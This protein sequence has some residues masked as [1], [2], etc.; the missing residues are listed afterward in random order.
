MLARGRVASY[1]CKLIL[2][3][4]L[5]YFQLLRI[6]DV[7]PTGSEPCDSSE[8]KLRN[9]LRSRWLR[10]AGVPEDVITPET[11][12]VCARHF[13]PNA[14]QHIDTDQKKMRRLKA[15]AVPLMFLPGQKIESE[16]KK[17]SVEIP[18]LAFRATLD[19]KSADEE[20][21]KN[22]QS[23]EDEDRSPSAEENC[24]VV[25]DGA[26]EDY[27][28]NETSFDTTVLSTANSNHEPEKHL[29]KKDSGNFASS[30][31]PVVSKGDAIE[32]V[33]TIES[34]DSASK[35]GDN[36][37]I[38]AEVLDD[39]SEPVLFV[40]VPDDSTTLAATTAKSRSVD[41]I[42]TIS[43]GHL[44]LEAEVVM[45]E[46]KNTSATTENRRKNGVIAFTEE[47]DKDAEIETTIQFALI[48]D[49]IEMEDEVIQDDTAG[50][51][52]GQTTDE[53]VKEISR[54]NTS[55]GVRFSLRNKLGQCIVEE[56]ETDSQDS[57]RRE[58]AAIFGQDGSETGPAKQNSRKPAKVKPVNDERAEIQHEKEI[59][60]SSPASQKSTESLAGSSES[61]TDSERRTLRS[62]LLKR[63]SEG[64]LEKPGPSKKMA[65]DEIK[66]QA[67]MKY[68]PRK[69]DLAKGDSA[70]PSASPPVLMGRRNLQMLLNNYGELIAQDISQK[71]GNLAKAQTVIFHKMFEKIA[72]HALLMEQ[73]HRDVSCRL[74]SCKYANSV[75]H[76]AIQVASVQ[77]C[78]P[79]APHVASNAPQT[80][81]MA[82][83]QQQSLAAPG[84][85]AALARQQQQQSQQVQQSPPGLTGAGVVRQVVPQSLPIV[86][87]G[88]PRLP[89]PGARQSTPMLNAVHS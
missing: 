82:P 34:E 61:A 30:L 23:R 73:L 60:I 83:P 68:S 13:P 66:T 5:S 55:T 74:N 89:Q 59:S 39:S 88:R 54:P 2:N 80:T 75:R 25:D 31:P 21:S 72:A 76:A 46:P 84:P 16:E 41:G 42:G 50:T 67:R 7:D 22:R 9:E 27:V 40:H 81:Q 24:Q 47:I 56:T 19:E 52:I 37:N 87:R 53:A 78:V 62:S 70:S 20:L 45:D 33:E 1:T 58:V 32:P 12:F 64:L 17:T 51:K 69:V 49:D 36:T 38:G 71:L 86:G 85:S 15:H 44:N 35:T 3:R 18:S 11:S 6:P 57:T 63:A 14:Y 28:E 43:N 48:N 29:N 8:K 79:A 4:A 26:A 65:L 77:P 10:L